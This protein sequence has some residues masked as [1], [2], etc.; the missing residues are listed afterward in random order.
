MRA[1]HWLILALLLTNAASLYQLAHRTQPEQPASNTTT[2]TPQAVKA[3]TAPAVQQPDTA[4]KFG[5]IIARANGK[6]VRQ[7]E[8]L[9]YLHAI[10]PADDIGKLARY[11][12]IP[13]RYIEEAVRQYAVDSHIEDIAQRQGMA[14]DIRLLA[15]RQYAGR[16]LIRQQYLNS[17]RKQ[18][19]SEQQ[20]QQQYNEMAEQLRQQTETHARHILLATKKEANIIRRA[21]DEKKHSFDE[22]AKLFSLDGAT[23]YKGGDLDYHISG[24][25]NPAF[26]REIAKLPLHTWSQPFQTPLGWHIAVVEDRRAA[27]VMPYEQAKPILRKQLEQQAVDQYLQ[28]LTQQVGIKWQTMGGKTAPTPLAD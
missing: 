4:D 6:P 22:L 23:S 16:Q 19:V 13:A 3:T 14:D 1:C 28:K 5:P 2:S 20:I 10:M 18:L 25:L 15:T 8:L 17:I 26:E 7:F 27:K 24:Q 9:P 12:D 21:L 11:D